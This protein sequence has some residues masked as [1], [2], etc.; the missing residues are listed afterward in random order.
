VRRLTGELRPKVMYVCVSK[1][2][3]AYEKDVRH[4]DPANMPLFIAV[5]L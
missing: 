3:I 4:C 1:M 5:S 2:K